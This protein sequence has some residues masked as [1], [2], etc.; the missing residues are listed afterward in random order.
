M[1]LLTKGHLI[2]TKMFGRWGVLIRGGPL[3][4]SHLF[5][6]PQH[7]TRPSVYF[8]KL[9]ISR[10]LQYILPLPAGS[11][12]KMFIWNVGTGEA[13]IEIDCFTDVPLSAA[14]SFDGSRI[15]VSCKD[16]KCRIIDP[17]TGDVVK[18]R[19]CFYT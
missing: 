9:P 4:I 17:R 2:I 7:K 15:V 6:Y 10:K 3:Y 13:L 8:Q 12:N 14:W 5:R 19:P 11:D 16:R 1:P 18:V